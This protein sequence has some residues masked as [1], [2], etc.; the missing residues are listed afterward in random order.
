MPD[1]MPQA[2]EIEAPTKE[3]ESDGAWD[4]GGT[5]TGKNREMTTTAGNT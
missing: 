3:A 2:S 1:E 5:L 4:T